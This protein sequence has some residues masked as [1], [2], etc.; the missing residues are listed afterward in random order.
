MYDAGNAQRLS[1]GAPEGVEG[2]HRVPCVD[3]ASAHMGVVGGQPCRLNGLR[4]ATDG[5]L[6]GRYIGVPGPERKPL[7]KAARSNGEKE[8]PR[9]GAFWVSTGCLQAVVLAFSSTS[10]DVQNCG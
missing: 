3:R 7:S 4:V 1:A 8:R 10:N 2:R 9:E 5:A 6:E